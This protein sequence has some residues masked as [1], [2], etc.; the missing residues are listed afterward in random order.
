[1][2]RQGDILLVPVTEEPE[3]VEERISG[4]ITIAH[5][6]VTGHTHTLEKATWLQLATQEIADLEHFAETGEGTVF[7]DVEEETTLTHQEH[8]PLTIPVGLYEVIR[9]REY[10]PA[11]DRFVMD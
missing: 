7:V 10:T 3:D 11:A 5:G 6:E 4:S 9:Q 1:M 2:I 8:S